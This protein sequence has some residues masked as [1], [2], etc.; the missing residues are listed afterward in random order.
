MTRP[1]R[2]IYRQVVDVL[3]AEH[4]RRKLPDANDYPLKIISCVWGLYCYIHRLA[5]AAVL[6]GDGGMEMEANILVRVMLEHTL[7]LHWI[8]ERGDE[9]VNAMNASQAKQVKRWLTNTEGT[10]LV[11]PPAIADE[12]TDSFTGIDESTALRT[13]KD[14][15]AQIDADSLYA[16]YGALSSSVHPTIT[17][18]NIF[19]DKMGRL[20]L[21]PLGGYS[22][23]ALVA[24]CLIWAERDLDRITPN[25]PQADGLEKLARAINAR[26]S[27]PPYRAVQTARRPDRTR[28]RKT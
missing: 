11:V 7:V 17:T 26:P 5:R 23:V 24:H 4:E 25:A 16:V 1:D 3:L 10:G 15:C 28:R 9:G 20:S 21:T 13:F 12:M 6:L 8:I 2:A 14:V 18:S 27:L 19:I 22:S